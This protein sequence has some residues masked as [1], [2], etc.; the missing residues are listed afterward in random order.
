MQLLSRGQDDLTDGEIATRLFLSVPIHPT[1]LEHPISYGLSM[2]LRYYS[3]HRAKTDKKV[4]GAWSAAMTDPAV[5]GK[6]LPL[7]GATRR[8]YHQLTSDYARN[9]G[10]AS[11]CGPL[12]LRHTYFCNLARLTVDLISIAHR[13]GTGIGSIFQHYTVGMDEST[14]LSPGEREFLTWLMFPGRTEERT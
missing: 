13:S 8:W 14:L 10:I 3:F 7:A 4:M 1:V 9:R 11:L 6:V 12:R 5:I 2:G